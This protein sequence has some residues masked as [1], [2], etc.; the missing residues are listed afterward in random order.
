MLDRCLL[1]VPLKAA[2]AC[3]RLGLEAS[4]Q[5]ISDEPAKDAMNKLMWGA[6]RQSTYRPLCLFLF[7]PSHQ[8]Y[9]LRMKSRF[10]CLSKVS[11][12]YQNPEPENSQKEPS[13]RLL[14]L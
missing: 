10:L 11:I 12:K 9:R 3:P 5:L 1:D 14:M 13:R 6:V 7:P 8:D 2:P 4:G